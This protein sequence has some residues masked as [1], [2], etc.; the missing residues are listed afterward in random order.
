M[1][2]VKPNFI[3]QGIGKPLIKTATE[4]YNAEK[5]DI[6]EQNPVA[7][8]FYEHMGFIV[9]NRSECDDYGNPFPILH[10]TL[11]K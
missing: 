6:N 11:R 8:G 5:V 9:E 2:F 10:M 4:N 3:G 7:K 1:L